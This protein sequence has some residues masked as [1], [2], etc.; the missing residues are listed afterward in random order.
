MFSASIIYSS[1]DIICPKPVR[2]A[3]MNECAKFL[4]EIS[5]TAD[6]QY[7]DNTSQRSQMEALDRATNDNICN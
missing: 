3:I 2:S 4:Q 1:P 5:Y 6:A 7:A